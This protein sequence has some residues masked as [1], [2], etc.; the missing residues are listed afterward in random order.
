MEFRGQYTQQTLGFLQL[1]ILFL[2]LDVG[3]FDL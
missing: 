1:G 3:V 2:E